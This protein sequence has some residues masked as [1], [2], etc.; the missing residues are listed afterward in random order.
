MLNKVLSVLEFF[1]ASMNRRFV[2]TKQ[3]YHDQN[4]HK[5]N[6]IADLNDDF[7]K[8]KAPASLP[9][10]SSGHVNNHSFF[11]FTPHAWN[12]RSESRKRTRDKMKKRTSYVINM[13]CPC[14]CFGNLFLTLWL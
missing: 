6:G 9:S 4:E 8:T 11:I 7:K 1:F 13:F 12:V 2:F 10:M 5:A 14:N 3:A